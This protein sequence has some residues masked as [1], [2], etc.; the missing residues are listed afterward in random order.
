MVTIGKAVMSLLLLVCIAVAPL[1]CLSITTPSDNQPKTEVNVG[2]DRGVT[3][4][5]RND[6]PSDNRPKTDVNVGGDRGVTVEH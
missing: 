1:A 6:T 4:E 5:H 2:G 3:V